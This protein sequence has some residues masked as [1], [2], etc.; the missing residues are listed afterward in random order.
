VSP[1]A[2]HL[3]TAFPMSV[4]L[5]HLLPRLI[6]QEAVTLRATC[7]AIRTIVADM[8]ADLG[9]QPVKHLKAMLTCFPKAN[10]VDLYEEDDQEEDEYISPEEQ[11]RL[12]AWLKQLGNSL[13]CVEGGWSMGP[14]LLRA[15]R[16]GVFKTVKNMSLRLEREGHRD[17]IIEGA[18]SGVE[19]IVVRL[20]ETAPHVE[21]SALGYLRHFP[22]L[23]KIECRMG[24]TDAALPPFI[25]SSLEALELDCLSIDSGPELLLSCLPP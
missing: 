24:S 22:A 13:T 12:I 20:S 23:K 15:W 5:D 8:R 11:E 25:P 4:W 14:F 3:A 21:R 18:V 7:K 17:L 2:L 9:F 16:A 1:G 6:L 10:K 19:S